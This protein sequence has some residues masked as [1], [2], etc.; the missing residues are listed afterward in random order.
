MNGYSALTNKTDNILRNVMKHPC[1]IALLISLAVGSSIQVYNLICNIA[2]SMQTDVSANDDSEYIAYQ[3]SSNS[4]T[5]S[6]I[7]NICL[8]L[9]P[10]LTL[11]CIAVQAK[12]SDDPLALRGGLSIGSFYSIA[13][14]VVFSIGLLMS[15]I[16]EFI[17][18]SLADNLD[19]YIDEYYFYSQYSLDEF[20][21]YAKIF[22]FVLIMFM[23]LYL[24]WSI[25]ATVF[26]SS[27]KK[28]LR[29]PVLRSSGLDTLKMFSVFCCLFWILILLF[30]ILSIIFSDDSELSMQD[31]TSSDFLSLV[32]SLSCIL[33]YIF[34][35]T[36]LSQ[37]KRLSKNIVPFDNTYYSGFYNDDN[38]SVEP[39]PR[40][41]P[42][43]NNEFDSPPPQN[44][45]NS[46]NQFN[47][48]DFTN[49]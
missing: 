5:F 34:F 42:I 13:G 39:Y 2:L 27:A 45:V 36:L 19:T 47:D 46:F 16:A 49:R 24:A 38:A 48:T 28:Q 10:F 41:Y 21:L 18:M 35:N 33:D 17:L 8:F 3:F 22:V 43:T 20:I 6:G 31:Y 29:N 11:L 32:L 9:L 14:I 25:S 23:A 44:D 40:Q 1:T 15:I 30:Q 12:N 7:I 4:S 37:Y 26:F